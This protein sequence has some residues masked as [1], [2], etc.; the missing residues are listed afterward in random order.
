[1]QSSKGQGK[2]GAHWSGGPHK[3]T[4][5]P[6]QDPEQPPKKPGLQI[7]SVAPAKLWK[8]YE[9]AL[10]VGGA[11]SPEA[12]SY[13]AKWEA[14]MEE[15]RSKISPAEK[16]KAAVANLFKTEK[17]LEKAYKDLERCKKVVEDHEKGI[18]ATKKQMVDIMHKG[19]QLELELYK[20]QD[21]L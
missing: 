21:E 7:E 11:N 13:K 19:L 15:A 9:L 1:M 12:I 5:G 3:G 8:A 20:Y 2:Q 14:A 17:M 6:N 18:L 10:E 16:R 4:G